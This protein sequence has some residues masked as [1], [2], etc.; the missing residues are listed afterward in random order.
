MFAER[1]H[2]F[3]SWSLEASTWQRSVNWHVLWREYYDVM[4]SHSI[5]QHFSEHCLLANLSMLTLSVVT[6]R[7]LD[8]LSATSTSQIEA[9]PT[10]RKRYIDPQREHQ[11]WYLPNV[12]FLLSLNTNANV[13]HPPPSLISKK[14]KVRMVNFMRLIL[15]PKW[16]QTQDSGYMTF[17]QV[18]IQDTSDH[19]PS[20][21]RGCCCWLHQYQPP[22]PLADPLLR[23]AIQIVH[24]EC[25][26]LPDMLYNVGWFQP[27]HL[28]YKQCL[29]GR[30]RYWNLQLL[31]C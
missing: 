4:R 3:V 6:A 14:I 12:P 5:S 13:R 15:T 24:G 19:A 29:G 10:L 26:R 20:R 31:S 25:G 11:L 7:V 9:G 17:Q 21:A 18:T 23:S 1:K 28:S 22:V 27:F 16:L 2:L 30:S 8:V